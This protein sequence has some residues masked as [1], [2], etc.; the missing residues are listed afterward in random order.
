[1]GS[2]WKTLYY[3]IAG[4]MVAASIVTSPA[5]AVTARTALFADR[6]R[7]TG[8]QATYDVSPDGKSFLMVG[9]GDDAD[10]RLVVVTGWL[11]ELRERMAQA[12]KK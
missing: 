4:N 6:F 1:M 10:Q 3:R 9:T 7:G 11:D 2:R 5:F 12:T 8:A